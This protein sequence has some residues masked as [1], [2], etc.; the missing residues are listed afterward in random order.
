MLK[1]KKKDQSD[2]IGGHVS[3]FFF[4]LGSS[5][6]KILETLINHNTNW[7]DGSVEGEK[8]NALTSAVSSNVQTERY[9]LCLSLLIGSSLPCRL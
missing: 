1:K 6:V 5:I 4:D 9:V 3:V 2:F 7:Q 8:V